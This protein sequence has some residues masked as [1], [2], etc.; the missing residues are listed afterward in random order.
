VSLPEQL[1][2]GVMFESTANEVPYVVQN[3]SNWIYAGTG[4]TDGSKINGIVGYEYDRVF[5][6]YVD[7][8][9]GQT[10]TLTPQPGLVILSRSPVVSSY[11]NSTLY[12][13]AGGGRVF[14]G[15]TIEWSSGLDS[16]GYGCTGG[17]V[18]P[19][20]QKTTINILNQFGT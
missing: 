12:T 19:A 11:S 16:N 18:S 2:L 15:G 7:G 4:L 6:T 5:A 3:S 10:I 13:V 1:L 17:C 14:A 9:T 8:N 20:L